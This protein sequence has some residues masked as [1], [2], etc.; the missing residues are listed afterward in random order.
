MPSKQADRHSSS[1]H[2]RQRS[3][4]ESSLCKT[5]T[6]KPSS[7][8]SSTKAMTH[9]PS[10]SGSRSNASDMAI[11]GTIEPMIND[12]NAMV[13]IVG[14]LQ[15]KKSLDKF[16]TKDK[17][18]KRTTHQNTSIF[19]LQKRS[20]FTVMVATPDELQDALDVASSL[21]IES[22]GPSASTRWF[23]KPKPP[24]KTS[25]TPTALN[26]I[27]S[28]SV[29]TITYSISSRI[30]AVNVM[31]SQST[32]AVSDMYSLCINSSSSYCGV[33]SLKWQYRKDFKDRRLTH[34]EGIFFDL[35][36][37]TSTGLSFNPEIISAM[38][39]EISNRIKEEFQ[40]FIEDDDS[41][42]ASCGSTSSGP[43]T[44]ARADP[45]VRWFERWLGLIAS[46]TGAAVGISGTAASLFFCW[47]NAGGF[48]VKG[49]LGLYL[50]G[51]YFNFGAMGAACLASV[52]AG[53][54]AGAAIYYIPWGM[55]YD[56]LKGVLAAVWN[57][58]KKC[59]SWI[60]EKL[61]ALVMDVA[62][63][64]RRGIT[65]NAFPHMKKPAGFTV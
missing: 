17:D 3:S 53:V 46:V 60:W 13:L 52:G 23:S 4:P 58:I 15:D 62:S 49:P 8:S 45:K 44:S 39:P 22:V 14:D 10:S 56:C 43:S 64:L 29:K 1:G 51:G 33:K 21:R 41:D 26:I 5:T 16:L 48:Y 18:L 11:W 32:Q 57:A 63:A 7:G 9:K 35:T 36:N 42:E 30:M 28:R 50:S 37:L 19:K 20:T 2:A 12:G 47:F 54:A 34:D 27:V 59:A 65:G 31:L 40:G 6:S 55:V 24:E 61:K 38:T 25:I